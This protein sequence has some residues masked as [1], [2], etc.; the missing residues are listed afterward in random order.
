MP[1][2]IL[3]ST[4]LIQFEYVRDQNASEP[5]GGDYVLLYKGNQNGSL[6]YDATVVE[7]NK[8]KLCMAVKLYLVY[9]H[10]TLRCLNPCM[11]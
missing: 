2:I 5:L 9:N 1:R 7:V 11:L 8:L 3:Q 10:S 6:V 4:G